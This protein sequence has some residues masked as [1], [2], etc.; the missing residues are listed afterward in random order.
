MTTMDPLLSRPSYSSAASQSH[1]ISDV[2]HAS[3]CNVHKQGQ[4][5]Q[6]GAPNASLLLHIEVDEVSRAGRMNP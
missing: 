4:L 1:P 5:L 6:G 3:S 2:A